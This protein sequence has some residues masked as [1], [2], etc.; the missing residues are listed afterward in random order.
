MINII[1]YKDLIIEE[2]NK[3]NDTKNISSEDLKDSYKKAKA[4]ENILLPIF[5]KSSSKEILLPKNQLEKGINNILCEFRKRVITLLENEKEEFKKR[6]LQRKLKNQNIFEISNTINLYLSNKYTRVIS[7]NLGHKLED[8]ATLSPKIINPEY[9][10]GF[11]IKGVDLIM[12]DQNKF[13]FTQIKTKKDTLT[14]SQKTRSEMELSI[15]SNSRF[16]ACL[17]L[18]N[19]TFNTN[20]RNI[21]RLTGGE[22]WHKID[23]DYNFLIEKLSKSI[24]ELETKLFS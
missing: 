16:V 11:K 22:F 21:E 10:F 6:H 18:G 12:Y 15:F 4:I 20:K 7:E 9:H 1:K 2:I 23:V 24:Q 8:I 14:G 5:I 3:V 19:W 17:E 13:Y